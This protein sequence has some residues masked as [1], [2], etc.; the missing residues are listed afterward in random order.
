MKKKFLII[1]LLV[2][3]ILVCAQNLMMA[4]Y[5]RPEEISKEMYEEPKEDAALK[6]VSKKETKEQIA[7]SVTLHPFYSCLQKDIPG[8]NF[9]PSGTDVL[10]IAHRNYLEKKKKTWSKNGWV[11]KIKLNE[12]DN[13]YVWKDSQ[14]TFVKNKNWYV[15][16]N[17]LLNT[18]ENRYSIIIGPV[19]CMNIIRR[20]ILCQNFSLINKKVS[21]GFDLGYSVKLLDDFWGCM[22]LGTHFRWTPLPN[23]RAWENDPDLFAT[24]NVKNKFFSSSG[25]GSFF[26]IRL[27]CWFGRKKSGHKK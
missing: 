4:D 23:N 3:P 6:K 15:S 11:H 10:R 8:K 25:R 24:L 17:Y 19:I 16:V 18:V 20:G 14:S 7:G 27:A 12:N 9:R 5:Y 13:T 1:L 26:N 22:L 21:L 2:Q